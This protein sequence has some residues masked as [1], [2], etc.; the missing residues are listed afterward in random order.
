MKKV[1]ALIMALAMVFTLAACST[2]GTTPA[3]PG[4]A[5]TAPAAT[6]PAS[7]D[8]S[9]NSDGPIWTYPGSSKL[10]LSFASAGM[11]GGYYP[12]GIGLSEII[13]DALGNIEMT[14]EVTGG[15]VENAR[16]I[17]NGDS[18]LGISNAD[19]VYDAYHGMNS[20]EGHEYTDLRIMADGL[21]PGTLHL[22]VPL[23]SGIESYSD[24]AGKKVSI[25]PQGGTLTTFMPRLLEYYGITMDDMT[26]SYL[27][28]DDSVQGMIDGSLDACVI[29]TAHPVNAIKTL[30]AS[31]M[32]FKIIGIEDDIRADFLEKHPY[33]AEV[34]IPA[35]TYELGY[36]V[37][38]V[39]SRN[40]F[41]VNANV[42]D[43]VVYN[44]LKAMYDD[45]DR[46]K[47]AHSYSSTLA[48]D[49]GVNESIPMHPGAIKFFTDMGVYQK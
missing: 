38:T 15:A 39:A 19:A 45:L 21:L 27:S 20:Y 34:T 26:G 33:Y 37:H 6:A 14:V 22:A 48:L 10:Y 43:D 4:T 29:L 13:S 31:T 42:E 12:V 32:D 18:D 47:L 9:G 2:G 40:C 25:G 35:D 17:G 49:N 3:S 46:M 28:Y 1:V 5:A 41:V 11:G 7:S 8:S 44:I 16:L 24:L 36:E 23:D 30:M